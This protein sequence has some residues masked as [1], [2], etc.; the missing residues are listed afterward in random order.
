[1]CAVGFEPNPRHAERLTEIEAAYNKCGWRVKF[2]T[3][4]GVSDKNGEGT[5]FTDEA[6]SHNEWGGGIIGSMFISNDQMLTV[7]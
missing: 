2:F 1:M 7:C 4:T 6:F 3:S 5:F